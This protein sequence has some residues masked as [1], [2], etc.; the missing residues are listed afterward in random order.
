VT[1]KLD[2]SITVIDERA[3]RRLGL[4]KALL[5]AGKACFI[6]RPLVFLEP[7][8]MRIAKNRKAIRL[9]GSAHG[10]GFADMTGYA[11]KAR[12]YRRARLR[13]AN[14][15]THFPQ[16]RRE[17]GLRGDSSYSAELWREHIWGDKPSF[18]YFT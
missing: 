11:R 13:R 8:N 6:D 3:S 12:G 10:G 15:D 14:R 2:G 18:L 9:E 16:L 17:T 5:P 4:I 1:I 7:R